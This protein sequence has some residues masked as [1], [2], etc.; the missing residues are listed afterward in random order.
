[1]EKCHGP[2]A[3]QGWHFR[4]REK[5]SYFTPEEWYQTIVN[6]LVTSES[7]WLDVGSGKCLFPYNNALAIELANRCQWLTGLDPSPN[8]EYNEIVHEKVQVPLE[9]FTTNRTYDLA[10]FHMV[11]E[12]IAEPETACSKLAEIIAPE[13]HVVIYTP[14][15]YS[16]LALMASIVPNRLHALWTKLLTPHR[17]EEDVFPT[18]YRMNTR[19]DLARVFEENEFDEVFFDYFPDCILFHRSQMGTRLELLLWKICQRIRVPYPESNLIAVFKK[20]SRA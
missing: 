20:R 1:M 19:R 18:V 7:Q 16:L 17:K 4:M 13:G 5:I 2:I 15:K 12:H 8:L 6:Q 11:A 9:Q 14:Y 3:N 10:T